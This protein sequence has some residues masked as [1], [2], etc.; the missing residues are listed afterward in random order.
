MDV[1]Q[2]ERALMAYGVG[3]LGLIAVKVLAPGFYA[4]QELRT[5][6]KIA[7]GV[8]ITTQLLNLV[9]VPWLGHAGLA[10]SIS[11]GALIN[12]AL[13]FIG[14]R[15]RKAYQPAPGWGAFTLRVLLASSL[16]GGFLA[17]AAQAVPW[18]AM[19]TRDL[20]RIGLMAVCIAVAVTLYFVTLWVSGL[21]FR[22]FLRRG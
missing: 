7:V 3:L 10:L 18:I 2:T 4:R 19:Q 17:W 20:Q 13:L 6:V 11:L 15:R 8:L 9:F 14:L 5:P 12:S 16:M 21:N 22:Q 1:L